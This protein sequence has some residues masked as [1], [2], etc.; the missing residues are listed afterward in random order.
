MAHD[1]LREVIRL[2]CLEGCEFQRFGDKKFYCK[3]YDVVL[4][5]EYGKENILVYRYKECVEEGRIGVSEEADLLAGMRNTLVYLGDH[6]Y[7]F[8]DDFESDLA[9]LY[10]RL[11]ALEEKMKKG[12]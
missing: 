10:R 4:I 7:S 6:F 1:G 9:D 12:D 5:T 8:K 2:E 11:K 3:Y